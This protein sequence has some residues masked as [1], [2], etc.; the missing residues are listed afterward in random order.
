[1][2]V[3]WDADLIRM[4]GRD[5]WQVRRFVGRDWQIVRNGEK[6][7]YRINT[8]RVLLT[9]ARYG[10][11]LFVPRGSD[12]DPTRRPAI[13]DAIAEFLADCGVRPLEMAPGRTQAAQGALPLDP[14]RREGPP[15]P[16]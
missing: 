9:R 10:T 5:A 8:Y 1:M 12:A 14:A 11:I 4:P 6:I 3:V 13:Y 2:G 7:G 16:A 15:G